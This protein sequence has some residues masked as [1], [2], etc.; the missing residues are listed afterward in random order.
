[1]HAGVLS[2]D[3]STEPYWNDGLA[4]FVAPVAPTGSSVEVAVI[5]GGLA[6]LS[7]AL[8]LA[9]AG[10]AVTVFEAGKI[11]EGAVGRSAGSL[12]HVPKASLADLEARYGRPAALAVYREARQAREFV[13]GLV[14]K[15]CIACGLR[16]SDRFIAAHSSRAFARQEASFPGLRESW[17]EVELIPRAAQRRVIGSDAFFGGIKLANAAT[18]QPALLQRGLAAAAI[19][20]G[21]VLRQDCRVRAVRRRGAGFTVATDSGG[22]FAA[23]HVLLATN[24]D[25][26]LGPAQFRNLARRLIAVPA[27]CLATEEVAPDLVARV[28]P[29]GGPVSDTFKIINYIAPNENGRRFIMSAR[30][31]RTEGGLARKAERIFGYFAARFPDLGGVRV[32]HCWTGRFAITADWMPHMG[33][34]EGIHYVLGC[35]GTGIPMATWLGH[36]VALKILARDQNP[37]AF[38]RPLPPIAFPTARH[39][40]LPLA[41][42]AY[43]WRDQL[44]R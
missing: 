1:M 42:R 30:A 28:L 40:L 8:T 13:E 36:R 18:L 44:F 16:S 19:S 29:I 34:D 12:G 10:R 21:A 4:P 38:E 25:T 15:H 35:C 27:F 17:G 23:E 39:L 3:F 5:G 14:R 43:E 7:A 6:G 32:S 24:A 41:V 11:G 37:S 33:V 20:A 22:E 2:A 31:G 9:E 26:G